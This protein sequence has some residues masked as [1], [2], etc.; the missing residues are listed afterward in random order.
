[1]IR[2]G[3]ISACI[4]G[5]SRYTSRVQVWSNGDVVEVR[6]YESGAVGGMDGPGGRFELPGK[7]LSTVPFKAKDISIAVRHACNADDTIRRYGKPSKE[8]RWGQYWH[9]VAQGIS[10]AKVKVAMEWCKYMLSV[11]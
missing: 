1:M 4:A 3:E 8:F 10:V 6:L 2:I 7:V 5:D 9:P 11:V